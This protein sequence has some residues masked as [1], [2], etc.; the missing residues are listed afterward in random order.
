M[1]MKIGGLFLAAYIVCFGIPLDAAATPL[2]ELATAV[3]NLGRTLSM[4]FKELEKAGQLPSDFRLP[5]WQGGIVA[6]GVS[7]EKKMEMMTKRMEEYRQTISSLPITLSHAMINLPVKNSRQGAAEK[8]VAAYLH[9]DGT[10]FLGTREVTASELKSAFES[11]ASGE[12]A[13]K[14]VIAPHPQTAYQH[15][16]TIIEAAKSA[17]IESIA[18]K[19]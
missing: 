15:I 19:Q 6:S 1:L 16:S 14:L 9:S 8:T 11:L 13:V 3:E 18:L 4:H 12:K 7:E 5:D 2:E 10:A 17:G